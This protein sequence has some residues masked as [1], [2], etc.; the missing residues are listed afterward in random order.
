METWIIVLAGVVAL[1]SLV[2][3]SFILALVFLGLRAGRTASHIGHAV[4]D[5]E[6]PVD[7]LK[8]AAADLKE[9]AAIFA[10]DARRVR[11]AARHAADDVRVPVAAMS[12]IAKGAR[13]ARVRAGA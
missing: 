12:A 9:A 13:R 6:R 1:G 3:T 4:R 2:Q 8:D 7:N 10:A 11:D 5:L